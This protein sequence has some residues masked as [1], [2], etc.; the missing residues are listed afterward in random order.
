VPQSS[1]ARGSHAAREVVIRKTIVRWVL[2]VSLA[3]GLTGCG[4]IV[5]GLVAAV[6]IAYQRV[7]DKKKLFVVRN[8]DPQVP[9]VALAFREGPDDEPF[10]ADAVVP[11]GGRPQVVDVDWGGPDGFYDVLALWADG[12]QGLLERVP[13][14]GDAAPPVPLD[15]PVPPRR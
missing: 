13:V 5:A 10:E 11:P 15:F 2:V 7:R 8:P 9:I 14:E 4:L 3:P 6:G 1:R 12:R